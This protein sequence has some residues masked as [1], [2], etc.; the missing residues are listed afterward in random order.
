[1]YRIGRFLQL[2]G[3]S[4]PPLAMVAQLRGDIS[5]GKMLSFLFVAVCVFLLGYG[6]QQHRGDHSL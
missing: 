6:L 1:M 3:L 5:A 4:I 2:V